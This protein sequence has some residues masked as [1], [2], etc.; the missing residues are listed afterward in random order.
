MKWDR[1]CRR[2]GWVFT[3]FIILTAVHPGANAQ[4]LF[5]SSQSGNHENIVSTSL[6][7]GG[8]IRSVSYVSQ[9]PD[10]QNYYL[11]SLYAQAGIM[12]DVSAGSA[13]SG[14][15]ELRFR[16]GSEFRKE[17][18]AL[19]LREAYISL[20]A[21]PA[22]FRLGKMIHRWGKGSV[23]NPGHSLSPLDPTTRSP[24][25]NDMYLG[26][27]GLEAALSLGSFSRMTVH[28]NPLYEASILLIEPIPLPS[29]LDFTEPEF[30]G[31]DLKNGSYA[32]KYDLFTRFSDLSLSWFDGY[33]H[34]PGLVYQSMQVNYSTLEPESLILYQKAYRIRKAALDFSVPAGTFILRA[35]GAWQQS[36]LDR[37]NRE[38]IPFP[39]L[40][41]T[42][43]L[44]WSG[45]HLN[46]IAGYYGKHI[47][48]H[49]PAS[50]EAS[51]SADPE[52]FLDLLEQG[53]I[54]TAE[55]VDQMIRDRIAAFNRLYNYQIKE[56]YH[57]VFLAGRLSVFHE[58]VE[59]DFPLIWNGSTKE[60]MFRPGINYRPADGIR[61]MAGYEGFFGP[62]DSLY[63]LVGPTLNSV[64]LSCKITF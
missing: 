36:R 32:L 27:W 24:E 16:Y 3:S 47:L 62:E 10:D 35:E 40:A 25:E 22:S 42:A 60:W 57:S 49:Y 28:W 52:Q 61:I 18:A 45:S 17:V 34:W 43:E 5:E 29:Y 13:A 33:N 31:V 56:N 39:E 21:G 12:M 50:A 54:P 11:Q 9:S 7:L 38:Y 19:E 64:F 55:E 44:E 4:S 53:S 59:I 2:T 63:D 26:V 6:N 20:T 8:F 41:Y 46:L 58:Q 23:F 15:A 48:D 1:M 30:P 51:L 14:F 37:E